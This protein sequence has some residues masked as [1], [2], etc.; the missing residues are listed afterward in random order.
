MI[1]DYKGIDVS[2]KK[3]KIKIIRILFILSLLTIIYFVFS[4]IVD[5]KKIIYAPFCNESNC[6]GEIKEI[7]KGANSRCIPFDQVEQDLLCVHCGKPAKKY[8]YF[9]KCY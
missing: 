8:A 6:E 9:G 4:N 2:S 3:K 7:T 5:K 1:T